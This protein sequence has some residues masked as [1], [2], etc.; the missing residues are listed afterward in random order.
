MSL[1]SY[2]TWI[3]LNV[4]FRKIYVHILALEEKKIDKDVH[5]R[6]LDIEGYTFV[7]A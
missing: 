2:H 7:K 3:K 5:D 4:L 1:V 6:I